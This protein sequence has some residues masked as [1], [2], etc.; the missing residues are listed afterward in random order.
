[1]LSR[2]RSGYKLNLCNICPNTGYLGEIVIAIMHSNN[3][4]VLGPG[5]IECKGCA[6]YCGIDGKDDGVM[7]S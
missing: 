3:M 1:M 2:T 6:Y 5:L 4:D 7:L